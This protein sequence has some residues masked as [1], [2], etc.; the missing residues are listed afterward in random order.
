[1]GEESGT[2]KVRIMAYIERV[3]GPKDPRDL[4]KT[5]VPNE[6][7]GFV[8]DVTVEIETRRRKE[9]RYALIQHYG[10]GRLYGTFAEAQ[11]QIVRETGVTVE[12]IPEEAWTAVPSCGSAFQCVGY[13]VR[14]FEPNETRR[15]FVEADSPMPRRNVDLTRALTGA[16]RL[17]EIPRSD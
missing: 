11:Q 3:F 13:F 14:E 5:D 15:E 1:M 4:R 2:P 6:L 10:D 7:Q 9:R 12:Q 17:V 16:R 8:C